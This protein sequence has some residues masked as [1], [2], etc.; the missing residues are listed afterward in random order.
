MSDWNQF[1]NFFQKSTFG[2]NKKDQ[3]DFVRGF[4]RGIPDFS[5]LLSQKSPTQSYYLDK[6]GRPQRVDFLDGDWY[7][8]NGTKIK[9]KKLIAE[10][11]EGH[12]KFIDEYVRGKQEGLY[13]SPSEAYHVLLKKESAKE[14]EGETQTLLR[15]TKGSV[16][17]PIELPILSWQPPKTREFLPEVQKAQTLLLKAGFDVG[18]DGADGYFGDNTL[19]AV[20]DFQRKKGLK[21]TGQIDPATWNAL[22]EY[23]NE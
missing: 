4:R 5:F 19:K 7:Y 2:G 20:K 10:I 15:S 16:S 17:P 21:V 12:K 14:S 6:E 3:S 1:A 13:T 8:E 18:P 11:E 9:D 22:S 23:T